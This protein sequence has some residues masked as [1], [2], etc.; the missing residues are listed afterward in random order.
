MPKIDANGIRIEFDTFGDRDA[1][2]LVLVMG[3]GG[4]MLLWDDAFC[5]AL[6]SRGHF[7]LRFD[8]RDI[9]LSTHFDEAGVPDLMQLMTAAATGEPNA[10]AYTLD[11][12][13]DD[14]VGLIDALGIDDAH[15]VGASM[16]GMIVQ[17]VAVR[18]PA[19]VRSLT[20]IMSTTGNPAVPPARPELMARLGGPPPVGRQASIDASVEMWKMISGPGYPFDEAFIR[21]RS[22]LLYDR[23]NHPEGQARQLAAILA[24]GNR[25]PRLAAVR[26]PTL[27]IHGTDDPLVHVDGGKD[28]AASIPG[29]ELL[30]IPGMGH[31]LPAGLHATLVDAIASHTQKAVAARGSR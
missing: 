20:S 30:L 17:T 16:G 8:N 22:G 27:V 9:G 13:A 19:R 25:G 28:T 6:A 26:A 1:E 12:M 21:E 2:P 10:L 15:F 18:H 23:A 5:E 24:H 11:D 29:A 31:D 3:L 14:A 4:Q 7:V